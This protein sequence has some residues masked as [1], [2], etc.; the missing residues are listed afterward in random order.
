M[1]MRTWS[2][3]ANSMSLVKLLG[4]ASWPGAILVA[5]ANHFWFQQDKGL[6]SVKNKE[7]LSERPFFKKLIILLKLSTIQCYGRIPL[8]ALILPLHL[9]VPSHDNACGILCLWC[10]GGSMIWGSHQ[11]GYTYVCIFSPPRRR[12]SARSCLLRSILNMNNYTL[13]LYIKYIYI[14][15]CLF[16][17]L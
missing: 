4:C 10:V 15:Q 12:S 14:S 8:M 3:C 2:V 17:K 16:R 6:R 9:L 5:K 13:T 11:F 7:A 1:K